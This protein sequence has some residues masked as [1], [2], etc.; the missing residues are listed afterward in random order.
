MNIYSVLL[1]ILFFYSVNVY[2][3]ASK[4]IYIIRLPVK[5]E[6]DDPIS[7]QCLLP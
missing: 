6:L 4:I 1:F 2:G 5:Y 3:F 7:F